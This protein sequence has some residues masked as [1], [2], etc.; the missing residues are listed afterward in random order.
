MTAKRVTI[1]D[2]AEIA[3]VHR[4]TVSL[5]LRDDPRIPESTR[6]RIQRVAAEIGYLPNLV[7][8]GLASKRTHTVGLLVPKLRDDFY[9]TVVSCQEEWLRAHNLI[10][11]LIVTNIRK[12]IELPAIE[13]LIGRGVDGLVFNY[14]P[15]DLDTRKKVQQLAED[16]TPI[17]MFGYPESHGV[18]CVSYDTIQ[19]GYE[20]TQHLTSLGHRRIAI[21]TWSMH[22]RRMEGYRKALS[23]A[24]IPFDPELVSLIDYD[25]QDI[26]D[27]HRQLMSIDDP[28][29][30]IFAYS[31]DLA[32]EVM[33]HLINDGYQV[34]DDVSVAGF[35]D[36]WFSKLVR[37][38]LTTMRLPQQ[39]LAEALVE[40]VA[41]RI[42]NP[43]ADGIPASHYRTFEGELV[44]R[45]STGPPRG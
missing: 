9:V 33:N 3:G 24:D 43:S 18:D 31:D 21:L 35:D 7:A 29:T 25:H 19:M 28:P 44:V 11:L 5:A 4:S 10:P 6:E 13:E 14:Y 22:N 36:C 20:L 27:L 41:A 40:M 32:A 12:E 23:E 15:S 38:P 45:D 37:V 34:P 26:S 30:A 1:S 16:G 8:R 39:A 17:A 42:E 2:I